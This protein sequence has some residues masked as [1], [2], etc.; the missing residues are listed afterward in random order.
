MKPLA[1]VFDLGGVLV[2]V[3]SAKALR[4]L[5]VHCTAGAGYTPDVAGMQNLVQALERGELGTNAFY[6]AVC[7]HEALSVGVERFCD[8]Y[9]DIFSPIEGMIAAH[10]ALRRAGV[11]TYLF[12]NTSALHFER[13]RSR[14]AFMAGFGAYFLSYELG[15]MKPEARA[16]AAVENAT[17]HRGE[18]LVF[19][20]DRPENVEGAALRGWRAIRHESPPLTVAALKALGLL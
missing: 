19:I 11:A 14:N 4:E 6:E 7:R 18:E 15:C 9:C 3:D 20:D 13:I 8:A 12:S 10:A 1:V 5:R 17:G 2:H 16:Y